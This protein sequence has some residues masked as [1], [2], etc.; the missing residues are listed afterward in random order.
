ML[1]QQDIELLRGMFADQDKRFLA[2]IKDNNHELKRE[3]RD[4]THS[5]LRATEVRMDVKLEK[6]KTE[7]VTEVADMLD[8]SILPQIADLQRDI[9]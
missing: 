4:E 8:T 5:L 1:D 6:I 7:I 3:I 9:A 2:A